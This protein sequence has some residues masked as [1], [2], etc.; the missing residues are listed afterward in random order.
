MPGP[1]GFGAATTAV[2]P[3]GGGDHHALRVDRPRIPA[4]QRAQRPVERLRREPVEWT[5]ARN[6]PVQVDPAGQVLGPKALLI[7]HAEVRETIAAESADDPAI[8]IDYVGTD[9]EEVPGVS[10]FAD[11]R[12]SGDRVIGRARISF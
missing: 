1:T 5:I 9:I 10:Q 2:P 8:G 4:L 11:L 6:G 7:D 3:R 12:H